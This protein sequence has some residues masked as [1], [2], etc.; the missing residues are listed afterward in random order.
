[1]KP[2]R[3]TYHRTTE[4]HSLQKN[5]NL[6]YFAFRRLFKRKNDKKESCPTLSGTDEGARFFGKIFFPS[7]SEHIKNIFTKM[8]FNLDASA[9]TAT[10]LLSFLLFL[11]HTLSLDFIGLHLT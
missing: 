7:S 10:P 5:A 9:G 4:A 6:F 11:V 3:H 2:V 8:H 1:L